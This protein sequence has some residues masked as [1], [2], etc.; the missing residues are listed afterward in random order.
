VVASSNQQFAIDHD[1]AARMCIAG[2]VKP[3]FGVALLP[4]R[5]AL[6]A[7]RQATGSGCVNDFARACP[8]AAGR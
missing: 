8:D 5:A 1:S 3:S 4:G 6:L 2:D 7:Q